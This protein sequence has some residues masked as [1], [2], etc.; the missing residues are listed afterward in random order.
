M[1]RKATVVDIDKLLEITKACAAYMISKNIF[2]WNEFY[3]NKQAFLHDFNRDELY[4]LK[5]KNTVIGCITISTFMD[6]EY[7]PINWMTPNFNNIYIHRLA[8]HPEQQGKEYAQK[9]MDYAENYAKNNQFASIRLD[10]FSQNS[11]NVKFY[12]LRGYKRLGEIYFPRQ[13]NYSFFCYEL[14]F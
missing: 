9:L 3:P 1:I 14:V 8:I 11:R 13:S 6:E 4:V 5:L 10:T 2:Q 7:I 12:E